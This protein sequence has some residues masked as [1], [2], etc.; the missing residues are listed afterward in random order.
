M[1]TGLEKS[2]FCYVL[3]TASSSVCFAQSYLVPEK[4]E[5]KWTAGAEGGWMRSLQSGS[6]TS[7][8]MPFEDAKGNSGSASVFIELNITHD[9]VYTY[10]SF[11]LN[12]GLDAKRIS[13]SMRMADSGIIVFT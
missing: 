10:F 13:H 12:L 1:R 5:R 6:Y 8:D 3:L 9:F 4:A 7:M 11:G 2:F